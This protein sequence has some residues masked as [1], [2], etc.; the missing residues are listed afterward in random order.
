MECGH[1][2]M[3]YTTMQLRSADEGQTVSWVIYGF[4]CLYVPCNIPTDQT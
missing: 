1:E 4:A 3:E 2:E